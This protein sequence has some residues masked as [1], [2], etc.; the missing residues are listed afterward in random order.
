MF[1]AHE[2]LKRDKEKRNPAGWPGASSWVADVVKK[3]KIV[4]K[5]IP[6]SAQRIRSSLG[7]KLLAVL[8]LLIL[9]SGGV[10]GVAQI[11]PAQGDDTTGSMGVFR[12]T[13]SPAFYS[14]VGASGALVAYPGYN[15]AGAKLTSPLCIDSSTTIGRSGRN[16]RPYPG[17][18]PIAIGAGSWDSI[19]SY[20]SYAF[21]PAL[22]SGTAANTEEVLTEIKSFNLLSVTPGSAGQHCPPDPRIPEVPLAWPMVRAGTFAGV[23]P[24]SLGMVQENVVN[25]AANPDF[26]AHSFFD[27]FV[28]VNL[29]PIAG[30]VSSAAFPGTGAV[31]YNDTPLVI[32]NMNLTS[33]P[34]DVVYIH[35]ET[36]AVPLK[37]RVANPPYWVAGDIFG[38]LVLAGHGTTTN[39]DCNN[40][41]AVNALLN[42]ALG[43]PGTSRPE[44]PIE[45]PRTNTLCPSPG[46]SYNSSQGTNSDGSSIDEI[47]FP[48]GG[49]PTVRARN[50]KHSNL[51]NPINPPTPGN[52]VFY[53]APNTLV[54]FEYSFDGVT[55]NP[56]TANG[57]VQTK[58]T[59][60][61]S[62]G[63]TTN[64]STE[65][66][67]LSLTAGT[68]LIRESPSKQSLGKHTIR[69]D[70]TVFRISSFFDV[71]LEL[72]LD[73]GA[74]WAPADRSLR[75]QPSPPAA[76]VAIICPANMTV[77][78]TSAAGAVVN[79]PAS[80]VSG[81]CIAPS[82]ICNPPS[83]SNFPIGT[84][85]VTC[86]A[87]D[88]CGS[89]AQC[90][91]TVTVNPPTP[92]APE[93][94][95]AL[96]LLPP[97]GSVYISPA[98]WHV[99]FNNG[100]IIRDVRHRFF[101]Q[102]YPL[103]PLGAG[104]IETFSSEVDFD[105]STD[106]GLSY[107]PAS[108]TANVTVQVTNSLNFGGTQFFDTEMLQL[109]L[110]G[111]GFMLRESPTLQSTGK[112]TV[113]PVAG[114]YLISS[115]FDVFTE[116]STDGGATWLPANGAG[117]VEMHNDP[118]NVTPVSEPTTLLPP[119][120]GAYVSPQQ[121]HA[122]YAQGIVIRDV[123]HK[124]FTQTLPPPSVGGTN[125]ENFNSQLDLQVSTDGGST[126]SSVR[127]A[128]P[129]TVTV[130]SHGSGSSG[131]YDTEMT[132]L[133]LSGGLPGGIMIRESPTL[134]SY[135][136]TEIKPQT[137]GTYRVTSFFDIF[138]ELS[139]D[140]GATWSGATNGPVRVEL[141][142]PAPEIP[143]PS[144]NLP[145]PGGAY[146]SPAQWH[147]LYANGII[148]T[149]ASHDRF[150]QTQPPP[151]PGGSTNESFGSTVSG[152]V[153][154]NGGASFQP[155]SAPASVSVQVVSRADQDTGATRFF[156]TEM[157]SL[158]LSGGNL[159]AGLM[160]R[161]SP[162]KASLGR[163]SV[164][165]DV[166]D[167]KI[168]SFFDVFTEVSLDGGA[169]WLPSVTKPGTMG[170]KTNTPAVCIVSIS[171]PPSITVTSVGPAVVTF[172]VTGNDSCNSPVT[173]TCV[174][175]SG[176]TFPVG[177]TTVN[178]TATSVNGTANCSFTVTVKPKPR[179]F[180]SGD[181]LPPTNSVYISPAMWHAAYANGIYISN[182]THRAFTANYPPPPNGT[183]MNE[184]FGSKVDFLMSPNGQVFTRF[185]GNADCTVHVTSIGS[186][187]ND[188]V[189]DTEMLQ[190]DLSGGTMPAGVRLRESPT[191]QSTGQTR[192]TPVATGGYRISSFFDVFTELSLDNGA[193]WSPA[194]SAGHMELHIDAA[195]PPTK[196]VQPHFQG[197]QMMFDVPTQYGLRYT[198]QA[199]NSLTSPNN[200]SVIAVVSGNG[201]SLT[202]PDTQLP[203]PAQR[204]YRVVIDE[205]PNQ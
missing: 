138:T 202:V 68:I 49:G 136:Q 133:S 84:T 179:V 204:Y 20:A 16:A 28:E 45:W 56:A 156:D 44:L 122:L 17:S 63:G 13:V 23:T 111:P 187:G 175:P 70:G 26:P 88:T 148:I 117:H 146:V 59:H 128:A 105:L 69:P 89:T 174:P 47:K 15:P 37:F 77:T 118:A 40:S 115:F 196:L 58:I 38:Y 167:Y 161:E 7:T 19:A 143:K 74:T 10:S 191:K 67:Q 75:V 14:L 104:Q 172:T 157:L 151:A 130:A 120:N 85:T 60:S 119:P 100:I 33:F 5:I 176:S 54:N 64:Y 168:S 134:R 177:T 171:C 93:Y 205:D 141:T 131:L 8:T 41:T 53:S 185:T 121:W 178:C 4:M 62:S 152:Q 142:T 95:N 149:N 181:K 1:A 164:R 25:G 108:G 3:A 197:G 79:Y 12:V 66:L 135:G 94:F 18:F 184:T 78:A 199:N 162:S 11:F 129:V 189:Y 182:V 140:G 201:Q 43:P 144:N 192:I 42:A 200:W 103:P 153:S 46:S 72:S 34:P 160:V 165:T 87:S 9:L 99:L 76:P 71:F 155:F 158:N 180:P 203:H 97:S 102:H 170:L 98:L 24:R 86:T 188:Q 51:P 6:S 31:L 107:S 190:L 124:F 90:T 173:V 127:V 109:D 91:F 183:S 169:T 52:T 29:P 116:L 147:A 195:N 57:P 114:G 22:W 150:L 55:W 145:P 48:V 194:S 83:G 112:T 101:T 73:G 163:T 32:T 2:V 159:P 166:G 81:G 27:I 36:T 21:I 92:T 65:M 125:V 82:L 96:P 110:S 193:T 132:S 106:N 123:S 39:A 198:V 113:R 80:L 50:F 126:F 35:G 154:L 139:T 137:D 30:T 61:G 186:E